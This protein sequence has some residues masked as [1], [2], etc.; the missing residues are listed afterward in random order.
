MGN[1]TEKQARQFQLFSMN[2]F[3]RGVDTRVYQFMKDPLVPQS[4]L[5]SLCELYCCVSKINN[6]IQNEWKSRKEE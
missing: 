4:V 5:V 3:F 6:D 1:K 2:G